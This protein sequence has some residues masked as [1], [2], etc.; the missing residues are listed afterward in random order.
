MSVMMKKIDND[1]DKQGCWQ[2][3]T[4]GIGGNSAFNNVFKKIFIGC[5]AIAL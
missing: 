3:I 5:A 1:G 4:D 2:H